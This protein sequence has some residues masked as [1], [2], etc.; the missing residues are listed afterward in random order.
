MYF[1][2]QK[3]DV[4]VITVVQYNFT[5]R[6][7]FSIFTV[8]FYAITTVIYRSVQICTALHPYR[9]CPDNFW[10]LRPSRNLATTP[11]LFLVASEK[12]LT[13]STLVA[14]HLQVFPRYMCMY[15]SACTCIWQWVGKALGVPQESNRSQ[16]FVLKK[17]RS[18]PTPTKWLVEARQQVYAV[19]FGWSCNTTSAY[20]FGKYE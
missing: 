13:T 11:F 1:K 12:R 18:T 6:T 3:F 15:V 5:G 16:F 7:R 4:E 2:L 19:F 10:N 20:L 9:Y 14:V 8:L 17:T